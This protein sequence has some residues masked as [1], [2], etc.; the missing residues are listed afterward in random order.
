VIARIGV[1]RSPI[2][3]HATPDG[4]FVYVANQGTETE[5]DNTV[6]VIDFAR[7]AVAKTIRTGAGAHGVTVSDDGSSVFVTNIL[8][9]TVSQISVTSQSVVGTYRVGKGP[10]GISFQAQKPATPGAG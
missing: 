8:D 6:S 3:V 4:R 9:G 2:Q 10:N 1:G 5:P 7:G